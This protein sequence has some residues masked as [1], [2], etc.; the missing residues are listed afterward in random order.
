[1][2]ANRFI[3]MVKDADKAFDGIYSTQLSDLTKMSEQE[4][5]SVSQGEDSGAIYTVLIDVVKEASRKN[6][7]QAEL[8][9]NIKELGEKA[10][11]LA[12]KIPS[13][14]VFFE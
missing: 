13:L 6:I 12:M 14:A 2:K 7:A 10:T 11:K 9:S 4:F 1:M 8:V 5:Q 3:K